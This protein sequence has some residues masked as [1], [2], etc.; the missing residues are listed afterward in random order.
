MKK[1]LFIAFLAFTMTSCLTVK[2]PAQDNIDWVESPVVFTPINYG[3]LYNFYAVSNANFAPA[4]WHVP[5]YIEYQDM[6]ASLDPSALGISGGKLKETGITYWNTP[7]TGATN[8]VGFNLR[9]GGIID[10]GV[11]GN[12]LNYGFWWT[13]SS[14]TTTNAYYEYAIY[15]SQDFIE[16]NYYKNSGMA[17][18]LIKNYGTATSVTD[19]DGNVYPCVVIGG[20]CWTASNY[21]CTHLNDGTAIP[22][23]TDPTA[24]LLLSTM[25]YVWYNNDIGNK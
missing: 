3:A 14:Y 10:G 2:C 4:G 19:Y 23:V 7:N 8:E 11:F 24:W 12:I 16:N 9:G 6:K 21:A 25:G 22:N 13:S 1:L 17:V 5:T 20:I 18:R 15:N